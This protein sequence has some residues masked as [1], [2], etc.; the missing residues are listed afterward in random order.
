MK[1]RGYR[2]VVH[3]ELDAR[4]AYLF[5]GME[6]VEPAGRTTVL[7]GKVRGTGGC[8]RDSSTGIQ[9]LGLELLSIEQLA[10]PPEED[11]A[12]TG[13]RGA[14]AA[15]DEPRR[16]AMLGTTRRAEPCSR[17]RDPMSTRA[18]GE[19]SRIRGP[20]L[21]RPDAVTGVRVLVR[22]AIVFGVVPA[23]AGW[24]QGLV[25]GRHSTLVQ[26]SKIRMLDGRSWW[27]TAGAGVMVG[28]LRLFFMPRLGWRARS[29]LRDQRVEPTCRGRLL[30]LA[31]VAAGGA[32][33]GPEDALGKMGGNAGN[34]VLGAAVGRSRRGR[35]TRSVG[36]PRRYGGLLSISDPAWPT[37][38]PPEAGVQRR[39][40]GR[41]VRTGSAASSVAFA[42]Y[43]PIAGSTSSSVGIMRVPGRTAGMRGIRQ[44]PLPAPALSPAPPALT[45]RRAAI[46]P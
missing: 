40:A 28:V 8:V 23:F 30:V 25:G 27:R 11:R 21:R 19:E 39:H 32:S 13:T 46:R 43:F 1:D 4:F 24:R 36:C 44:R 5:D 15:P 20:R 29:K 26:L 42:V 9:E 31:G 22:C 16:Y 6:N 2:I 3:G 41:H 12:T 10:E 34:L 35:R 37:S 14:R 38:R 45:C 33:L 17:S 7:E 18:T